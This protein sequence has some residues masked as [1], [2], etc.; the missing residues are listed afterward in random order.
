MGMNSMMETNEDLVWSWSDSQNKDQIGLRLY[1]GQEQR[2]LVPD[3]WNG[4]KVT[5]LLPYAFHDC[6]LV[7]EI[8]LPQGLKRIGSHCFFDCRRLKSLTLWEDIESM[9]DGFLKNCDSLEE[10]VYFAPSGNLYGLKNI[11]NEISNLLKVTLYVGLNRHP[12]VLIFPKYLH[13][14]EENTMARII[15]E[16]THGMGVHYRECVKESRIDYLKYDSLFLLTKANE[17]SKIAEMIALFRIRYPF[18]LPIREKEVYL[19]YIRENYAEIAEHLMEKGDMENV[20]FLTRHEMVKSEWLDEILIIAREIG[21]VE[22][23]S[24]LLQVK[25][26]RFGENKKRFQL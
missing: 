12:V 4:R 1:Q 11:L 18:E 16:V 13:E 5:E 17:Q 7:E 21:Q 2:V 22:Y 3:T 8:S 23:V 26:E 14:Y 25:K 9:E 19:E 10:V 20:Q 24:F 15:N 6:R